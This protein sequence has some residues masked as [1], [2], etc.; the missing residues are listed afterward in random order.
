MLIKCLLKRDGGS[1]IDLGE[2]EYHFAPNEQ[3][4]H[5]AEVTNKDHIK[6]LLAIPEAYVEVKKS[7]KKTDDDAPDANPQGNADAPQDPAANPEGNDDEN[8]GQGEGQSQEG[9]DPENTD[10]G[11]ENE[12]SNLDAPDA[13]AGQTES[14]PK[15]AK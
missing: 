10:Q 12:S 3:G 14:K 15:K 2:K 1:K 13:N 8:Q 7:G 11:A 4:D 5:I 6:T 9:T